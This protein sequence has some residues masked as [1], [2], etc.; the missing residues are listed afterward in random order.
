[1]DVNCGCFIIFSQLEAGKSL[2][3]HSFQF[4]MVVLGNLIELRSVESH[5]VCVSVCLSVILLE[6]KILRLV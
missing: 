3:G 1:M 2:L 4:P 5:F 6:H